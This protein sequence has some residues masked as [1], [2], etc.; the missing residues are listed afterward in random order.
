MTNELFL[1]RPPG[2][3]V[4]KEA[5]SEPVAKNQP[6]HQSILKRCSNVRGMVNEGAIVQDA[7]DL[8]RIHQGE[9]EGDAPMTAGVTCFDGNRMASFRALA[10]LIL[11]TAIIRP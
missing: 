4:R 10:M 3:P 1:N 8:H 9:R 11:L 7:R 6:I 5:G 2:A